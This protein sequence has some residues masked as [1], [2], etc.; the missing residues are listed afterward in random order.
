LIVAPADFR[1]AGQHQ[2]QSWRLVN[3]DSPSAFCLPWA[4][5]PATGSGTSVRIAAE[6]GG[7]AR[8]EADKF[9]GE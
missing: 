2:R 3:S 7:R 5:N 1:C 8:K 9:A 6:V 4:P